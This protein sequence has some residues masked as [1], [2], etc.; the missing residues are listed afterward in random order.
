IKRQHI[1]LLCSYEPG[2]ASLCA[3]NA[4]ARW[5]RFRAVWPRAEHRS[6]PVDAD[7]NR[8]LSAGKWRDY[9]RG[10]LG[11]LHDSISEPR[12]FETLE[13][14]S[15][16]E[17]ERLK[18]LS[19]DGQRLLKFE[20]YG[21]FGFK[22]RERAQSLAGAGLSPQVEGASSGFLS[23]ALVPGTPAQG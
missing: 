13:P 5:R 23:Y 6:L 18:F 7:P 19:R 15:W 11:P 20:G 17:T 9:F 16:L 12:N 14:A 4:A 3:P 22:A 2:V 10:S 8:D 21:R 1:T